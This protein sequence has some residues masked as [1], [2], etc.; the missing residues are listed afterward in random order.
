MKQKKAIL[1][2][3]MR[4]I[5]EEKAEAKVLEALAGKMP[6]SPINGMQLLRFMPQC[7]CVVETRKSLCAPT[8][9]LKSTACGY[10]TCAEDL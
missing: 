1:E 6:V 2:A 8:C 3:Q 10:A 5:A 7:L 4:S 9:R